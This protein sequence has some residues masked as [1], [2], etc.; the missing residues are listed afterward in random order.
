MRP[1]SFESS[2]NISIW[3]TFTA[4]TVCDVVLT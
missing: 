1:F 3:L 4:D 2:R